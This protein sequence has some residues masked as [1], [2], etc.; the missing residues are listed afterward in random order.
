MHEKVKIG[1]TGL[2]SLDSIDLK[3]DSL[4]GMISWQLFQSCLKSVMSSFSNTQGCHTTVDCRYSARVHKL[5]KLH[6]DKDINNILHL[7]CLFEVQHKKCVLMSSDSE[8]QE[9]GS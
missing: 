6:N 1:F 5:T 8:E 4:I 7:I 2:V 9:Q 3:K